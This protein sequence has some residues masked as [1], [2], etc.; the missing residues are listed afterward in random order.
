MNKIV[1]G[2][3]LM[4]GGLM[5]A[6][7]SE[8]PRTTA[9]VWPLYRP[10]EFA[11]ASGGRDTAVVLRGSP[12]AMDPAQFEKTVLDNMQGQNWG[13][14]T[15]FTT[16]PTNFDNSYKVVMLFNGSNVN[17]GELCT[18][19]GVVPFQTGAQELHVFA[20]YCRYDQMMTQ[21]DGWLKPEANGLSQEGF[22]RLIRQMTADLFP[23]FN[24]DD[25]RRERPECHTPVC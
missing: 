12:L 6:C 25:P 4:L 7:S 21:S 3:C 8:I 23:A 16:K 14:R 1:V 2:V 22:A 9:Q 13:P 18:N 17:G 24:P 19:P 11:N 5:T 20:V 15:N 10:A